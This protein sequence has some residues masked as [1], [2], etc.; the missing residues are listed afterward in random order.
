MNS[1]KPTLQGMV[2]LFNVQSSNDI[3]S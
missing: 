1:S 3:I 2:Y